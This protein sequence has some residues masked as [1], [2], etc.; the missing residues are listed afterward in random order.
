MAMRR[1]WKRGPDRVPQF[2]R[3][4]GYLGLS[5]AVA[6]ANDLASARKTSVRPSVGDSLRPHFDAGIGVSYAC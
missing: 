4:T 2:L 1:P 6:L 3:D 5:M